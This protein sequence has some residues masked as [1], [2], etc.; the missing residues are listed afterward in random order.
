MPPALITA[1]TTSAPLSRTYAT[2]VDL[3]LIQRVKTEQDSEALTQ[4]A[5]GT[6]G[7]YLSIVNRYASV[8]PNTIRRE[9]LADD[10]LFN[11]YRFILDYDP[12]RGCKLSTYIGDRTHWMCKTLLK[13]DAQN[14]IRAGTYGPSGALTFGTLGD[15]YTTETG[16]SVT[17]A[18]EALDG[19]V[20]EAADKDLRLEDVMEAA[21][22]VPDKRFAQILALRCLQPDR[23]I[24]MAWREIGERIG[25]SHECARAIYNR[26]IAVIRKRLGERAA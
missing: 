2:E 3:A 5:A 17:L 15:T 11:L 20:V 8:Y 19:D 6:S 16:E 9:D 23:R 7:V 14:P 26:N 18:N 25:M 22:Q 13:Q 10:R 4:L 1:S 21:M 24:P 12:T